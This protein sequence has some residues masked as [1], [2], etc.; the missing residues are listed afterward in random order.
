MKV[1]LTAA[2]RLLRLRVIVSGNVQVAD[3]V[4]FGRAAGLSYPSPICSHGAE[5]CPSTISLKLDQ[6]GW[7]S[8]RPRRPCFLTFKDI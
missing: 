2:F 5:A 6:V 4:I 7:V 8:S 1:T 3:G